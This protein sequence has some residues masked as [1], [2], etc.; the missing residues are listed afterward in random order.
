MNALTAVSETNLLLKAVLKTIIPAASDAFQRHTTK[1]L[2]NTVLFEVYGTHNEKYY[3]AF[4][5]VW[6]ELLQLELLLTA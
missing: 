5:W 3:I 2:K 1:K 6:C 4:I